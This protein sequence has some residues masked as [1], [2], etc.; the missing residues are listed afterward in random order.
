MNQKCV[1]CQF[2][3][4]KEFVLIY[5]VFSLFCS[6]LTFVPEGGHTAHS[7]S[8]VGV[9]EASEKKSEAEVVLAASGTHE[10]THEELH[11]CIGVSLVLGFVFMLLVDQIGSSH[12]HNAE[13]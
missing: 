6:L 7:H 11:A 13:G 12:V 9:V 2:V 10:H 8:Q 1:C 4:N 5:S 3:V